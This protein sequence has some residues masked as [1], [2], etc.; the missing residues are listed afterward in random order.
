MG[1][2]HQNTENLSTPARLSV[3]DYEYF[4]LAAII[5]W[6]DFDTDESRRESLVLVLTEL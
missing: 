5:T 1:L 6:C 4:Q 3:C 2:Q